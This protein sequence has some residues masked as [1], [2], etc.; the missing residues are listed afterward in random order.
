M[1]DESTDNLGTINP[2]R[3]RS[4]YFDNE[5]GWY[6][7]NSRYYNPQLG[8]FVTMDEVEYLGASGS[9][10]GYNLYSYCGN[11]PVNMVHPSGNDAIL[12]V[13][14]NSGTGLPIVGHAALY[15]ES[16]GYWYK[17]EFATTNNRVRAKTEIMSYKNSNKVISSLKRKTEYVLI[18]GNFSNCLK[19]VEKE[20][21]FSGLYEIIFN[22]CLHYVKK[23][24]KKGQI[25]NKLFS[26]YLNI[27]QTYNPSVFIKHAKTVVKL[28]DNIWNR[29]RIMFMP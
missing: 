7:L 21:L 3:Y 19:Y 26:M 15:F 8:R 16:N 1:Q 17:T 12:V 18:E 10:L 27:S 25:N 23:L 6:Y 4:Y 28:K 14:Y 22:N 11:N 20:V 29:I 24:L 13:D 2:F 5:T 9:L